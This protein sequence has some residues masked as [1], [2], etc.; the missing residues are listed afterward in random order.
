MTILTQH[1]VHSQCFA[2]IISI[3]LQ[4]IFIIPKGYLALSSHFSLGTLLAPGDQSGFCLYELPT[5][6]RSHKWDYVICDLFVLGFFSLRIIFWRFIHLVACISNSFPFFGWI[7]FHCMDI[8][9][10][11]CLFNG[12]WLLG[13]FPPF[14]WLLWILLLWTF[15]YRFLFEYLFQ[16]LLNIYLAVV[17]LGHI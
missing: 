14:F 16:I 15:M 11:V 10:F 5:L 4:N 3:W 17:L 9:Y 12:W 13:L 8:Q 1:L 7:T 6:D 2:A